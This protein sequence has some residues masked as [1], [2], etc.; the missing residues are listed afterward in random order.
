MLIN[1]TSIYYYGKYA[2]FNLYHVESAFTKDK[3]QELVHSIS[4]CLIVTI[5]VLFNEYSSC[6]PI[7]TTNSIIDILF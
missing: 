1:K 5:P 3:I 6:L 2:I 4:I 7:S